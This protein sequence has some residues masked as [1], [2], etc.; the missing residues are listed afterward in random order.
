MRAGHIRLSW[1]ISDRWWLHHL[2]RTR[3]GIGLR[4]SLTQ[5]VD[6]VDDRLVDDL[7][8]LA[9]P[10]LGDGQLA[11][12]DG[13]GQVWVLSSPSTSRQ[14]HEVSMHSRAGDATEVVHPGEGE[15]NG[16]DHDAEDDAKLLRC[17]QAVPTY[18]VCHLLS[19]A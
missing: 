16:D 4:S 19:V 17:G 14:S 3:H 12:R 13:W 11:K 7:R 1:H 9:G 6:V 10:A 15:H 2:A 5:R 8:R 18:A